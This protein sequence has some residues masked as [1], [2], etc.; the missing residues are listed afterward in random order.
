MFNNIYSSNLK[1]GTGQA[2][3][4]NNPPPQAGDLHVSGF[5]YFDGWQV[6]FNL[7]AITRDALNVYGTNLIS[8]SWATQYYG[9]DGGGGPITIFNTQIGFA[10][11][12]GSPVPQY[13]TPPNNLTYSSTQ[14]NLFCGGL[15]V[16]A[17]RSSPGHGAGTGGL[18]CYGFVQ[19]TNAVPA[20]YNRLRLTCDTDYSRV[21]S[22]YAGSGQ[23]N[24]ISIMGRTLPNSWG[25][26]FGVNGTHY[27]QIGSPN[28]AFMPWTDNAYDIGQVAPGNARVRN[29]FAAGALATGV[30][31][32]AAVDGDVTF[33]TDG[34][35]RVDSTDNRLY[36]RYG[37]AWH[38]ATLT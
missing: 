10:G 24:A 8:A 20:N 34:M 23:Q 29:V 31:A 2:T 37:G 3:Y 22:E 18:L 6:G 12:P 32:G 4:A 36:V 33:P 35:L 28:W 30:K 38:Y 11:S 16:L 9:S 7:N 5:L 25:I 14:T 13:G 27:W 17:I 26:A 19:E 15:G 21:W 1:I